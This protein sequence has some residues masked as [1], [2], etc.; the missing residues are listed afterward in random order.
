MRKLLLALLIILAILGGFVY[1]IFSTTGYFRDVEPTNS[2][3]P[4]FQTIALP[5][6]ED[7]TI[8]RADSLL[9]LSVDDRAAR[10][11][12]QT[13]LAG[14]YLIDLRKTPFEPIPLTDHLNFP[15]FPHG[16][17]IY[18]IDSARYHLFAI[19][20]VDG[21]H[22]VEQFLLFGK[23]LT[24]QKT[25]TDPNFISPNDLVVVSPDQFYYSNDH[26]YT[27]GFGV[28]AENYLGLKASNVG[29]FNGE[30][31]EIK[32]G[33]IGYANG[34]Q[35]DPERRLLYV[36][37]VRAFQVK[38]YKV[39]ENWNLALLEDIPTGTGVDNI[40]LD[41]SG[42]LWIGAH[43]NLMAFAKYAAGKNPSA[44][45]EVIRIT[46]SP[47]GSEVKSLWTDPGDQMAGTSVA[48]PWGDYLFV[49]NVM[50]QKMLVM[51]KA[52]K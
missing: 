41:E 10:R 39:D 27:S 44:P 24:H 5:G 2:F 23:T 51:K 29:F 32:V 49:G 12:G 50:D 21:K 47:E 35:F 38:V 46:Y 48:L 19:N 6:V 11:D 15:F 22:S 45:S 4:V 3:G 25:I 20:H 7:M 1:H 8:A 17:S 14:L 16:L 30:S 28:F 43:P 33:K 31:A 9:I 42:A 13:G 26:G 37:S 36:A 18:Q 34:I 40:E 52:N